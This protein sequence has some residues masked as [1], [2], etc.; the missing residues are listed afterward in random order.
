MKGKTDWEQVKAM[1]EEEISEGALADP[2]NQPLPD[3]FW[4][5]AVVVDPSG[6]SLVVE[7]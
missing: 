5:D 7:S 2:D 4:E 3:D 1:T 6:N